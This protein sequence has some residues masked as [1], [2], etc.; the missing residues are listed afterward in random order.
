MYEMMRDYFAAK[1]LIA[2]IAHNGEE[3]DENMAINAERAY[4]YAGAMLKARQAVNSVTEGVANPRP[5]AH[6]P[7]T[8]AESDYDG[9]RGFD[10]MVVPADFARQLE[11]ACNDL[12]AA[13]EALVNDV[14]NKWG[15]PHTLLEARYAIKK[16]RGE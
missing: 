4:Q 3:S 6:T 2:L 1:A 16:A 9:H 8:D 13:L 11:R 15:D 10:V 14:E 7:R 5:A 12:L